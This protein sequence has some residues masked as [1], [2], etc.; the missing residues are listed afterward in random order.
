MAR[1]VELPVLRIKGFTDM[2][3]ETRLVTIEATVPLPGSSNPEDVFSFALLSTDNVGQPD[4]DA[5]LD[6]LACVQGIKDIAVVVLTVD[7]PTKKGNVALQELQF[8]FSAR[9]LS[10]HSRAERGTN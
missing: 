1:Q 10:F 4:T 2:T 6:R 9:S 5:R 8:R 3:A 7:T